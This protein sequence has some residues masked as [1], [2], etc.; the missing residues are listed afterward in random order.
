[1]CMICLG[2]HTHIG[3]CAFA[4]FVSVQLLYAFINGFVCMI[5]LIFTC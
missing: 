3:C 4:F 2:I 5:C 1:M